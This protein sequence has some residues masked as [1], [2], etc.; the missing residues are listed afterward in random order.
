[1]LRLFGWTGLAVFVVVLYV[2]TTFSARRSEALAT[3]AIG[4][5]HATRPAAADDEKS[6]PELHDE[7]EKLQQAMRTLRR[8]LRDKEQMPAA[9]TATVE[10]QLAAHRCKALTPIKIDELAEDKKSRA[11]VEYRLQ[12]IEV[13]RQLLELEA[14]LVAGDLAGAGEVYKKLKPLERS[15]HDK[16]R[17]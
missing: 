15:G 12:M 3:Q 5:P 8:S 14:K 4:R 1:M 10:A 11:K 16:F 17:D 6:N 2:G 9:L 13:C 7:M